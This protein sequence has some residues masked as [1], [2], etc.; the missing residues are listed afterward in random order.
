MS[1]FFLGPAQIAGI[2]LILQRIGEEIYSQI[3]TR[4]LLARGA[5][6]EN[7]EFYPIVAA[8]HV[9]WLAGFFLLIPPTAQPI[10]PL[11][12]LYILIQPVR[13]WIIATLG[14]Y[15]THGTVALDGAPMVTSGPYQY[16]R[17]PNYIVTVIELFLLPAAFGAWAMAVMYL[18]LW[19]PIVRYKI[20]LEDRANAARRRP[21]A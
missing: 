4:R 15:W 5:R 2:V 18:C 19:V 21:A 8:V 14:P 9:T 13:Y 17:H 6:H 7:R 11:L 16:V 20:V 1:D 3:N 10:W 12:I